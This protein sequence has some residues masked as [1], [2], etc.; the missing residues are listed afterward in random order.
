M[1]IVYLLYNI[2]FGGCFIIFFV[3]HTFNGSTIYTLV[4][5]L[6]RVSGIRLIFYEHN[7]LQSAYKVHKHIAVK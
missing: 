7:F 2:Y 3:L 5:A 4:M 6:K 1:Y